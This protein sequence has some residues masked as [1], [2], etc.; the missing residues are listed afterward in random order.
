MR[1][2]PPSSTSGETPDA[3]R[4]K[5]PGQVNTKL[6]TFLML[7]QLLTGMNSALGQSV[8]TFFS[9]NGVLTCSNLTPGSSATVLS[10]SSPSGPWQTNL[11]GLDGIVVG[12]NGSIQVTVPV[13]NA[14]T[15]FFRVLEKP[16]TVNG[17][18]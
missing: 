12:T 8:I 17:I 1:C 11:A 16:A 4:K 2:A 13:T 7:L 15:A 18:Y 3:K 14:A 6:V 5:Q 9:Q 10:A